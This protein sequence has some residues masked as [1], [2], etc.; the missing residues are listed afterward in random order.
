[1]HWDAEWHSDPEVVRFEKK[2][3]GGH[4][5]LLGL[6]QGGQPFAQDT[7]S[8]FEWAKERGAIGGSAHMQ[9]LPVAF[10]PPPD[11]IPLSLDCCAPLDYPVE[12]ALGSA[13]FLMEDVPG[14]DSALQAYYRIAVFGRTCGEH[15][16]IRVIISNRSAPF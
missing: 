1:V 3:L 8:I 4:Q 6:K 16:P 13:S 9:F 10:Y 15:R 7:Y 14:S 5:I 12:V 2:V 11:G